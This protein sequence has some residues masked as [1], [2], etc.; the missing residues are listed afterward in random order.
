MLDFIGGNQ[1]F[2]YTKT[3]GCERL[4]VFKKKKKVK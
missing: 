2:I 4:R 3:S 1:H